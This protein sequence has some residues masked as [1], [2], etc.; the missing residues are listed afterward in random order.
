MRLRP[1]FKVWW[2]VD[3]RSLAVFRVAFGLIC[4]IDLLLRWHH[5]EM[6]YTNQ[7]VLP[8]HYALYITGDNPQRLSLLY[9]LDEAWEVKTYFLATIGCLLCFIAGWRTRLFQILSMVLMISVHNRNGVAHIGADIVH[10]LWWLWT[11]TLPLG[12]SWSV[13]AWLAARRG[14]EL[15]TL[16]APIKSLAITGFMLQ[17]AVIYFFN[18]IHKTGPTWMKGEAVHWLLHQDR[19]LTDFGLWFREVMPTKAL[20]V[21]SWATLIVEGM[22]PILIWS[23]VAVVWCRRLL[24]VSLTGLHLNIA[25]VTDLSLFSYLMI[26]SYSLLL[27]PADCDLIARLGHSLRRRLGGLAETL[28]ST[29]QGAGAWLER[30]TQIHTIEPPAGPK[31]RPI[32]FWAAQIVVLITVVVCT[33]RAIEQN[34][35][36]RRLFPDHK[37]PKWAKHLSHYGDFQ[38]GWQLFAPDAP[39]KDGWMVLDV[40]LADGTHVDPRTGEAPD[41]DGVADSRKRHWTHYEEN[42]M[43]RLQFQR[44]LFSKWINWLTDSSL[45]RGEIPAGA[46]VV[47]LT[48]WWISD[49]SPPPGSDAPPTPEGKRRI[50]TW[51]K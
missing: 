45:D 5:I 3:P 51:K 33:H 43:F 48:A 42:L 46:E 32:R 41:L 11:I 20:W 38:Q 14:A 9:S 19:I 31:H 10:N 23:P 4:I 29:L 24:I 7:G 30:S 2:T 1:D 21:M 49:S 27:T 15:A 16:R 44:G 39:V 13:D 34:R 18:T 47:A 37:M 25:L 36:L 28:I 8:N 22:A 17:L 26:I 12:R 40:T 50:Y 6:M 35:A